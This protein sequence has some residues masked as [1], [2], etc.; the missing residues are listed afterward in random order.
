MIRFLQYCSND[1]SGLS[2]RILV[3]A[4][5]NSSLMIISCFIFLI[6]CAVIVLDFISPKFVEMPSDLILGFSSM[7][8]SYGK[9]QNDFKD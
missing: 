7:Y 6:P 3:I 4:A 8:E 9:K 1:H 2:V 5:P